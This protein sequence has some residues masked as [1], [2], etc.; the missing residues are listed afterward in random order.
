MTSKLIPYNCTS[1]FTWPLNHVVPYV[2]EIYSSNKT[3]PLTKCDSIQTELNSWF[4]ICVS[5]FILALFVVL[6][7]IIWALVVLGRSIAA[8][9]QRKQMQQKSERR[10]SRKS[11]NEEIQP[12]K[13]IEP[14]LPNLP[15]NPE[16][17][18]PSPTPSAKAD[19]RPK[20]VDDAFVKNKNFNPRQLEIMEFYRR[21]LINQMLKR[22]KFEESSIDRIGNYVRRITG[23]LF[24]DLNRRP[25]LL[26]QHALMLNQYWHDDKALA[27]YARQHVIQNL[28]LT[29]LDLDSSLFNTDFDARESPNTG[30]CNHHRNFQN[31][32]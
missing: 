31:K 26:E 30:M 22:Q 10:K 13:I 12:T 20:P 19:S 24:G 7:L 5:G 16:P 8:K 32:S 25:E 28:F 6:A 15:S 17:S 2:Y 21:L 27:A 1:N 29:P 23:N 14:T 9:R 11:I 18:I 3:S 4:Y